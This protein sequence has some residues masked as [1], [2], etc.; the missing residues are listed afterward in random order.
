MVKIVYKSHDGAVSEI[1]VPEGWSVMQ[2]AVSNGVDGIEGEC[3]G[4]CCCAT[5]HCYVEDAFAGVL[6]APNDQEEGMLAETVAE[7]RANSRLSCQIKVTP[8]LEGMVVTLPE[9]QS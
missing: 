4:S 8:A 3:G 6:P 1:D 7:R 2:A 9:A 5:C